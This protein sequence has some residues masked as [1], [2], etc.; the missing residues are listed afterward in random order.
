MARRFTNAEKGK[1]IDTSSVSPPRK[2]IRAPPVDTSDLVKENALT[3]IGRLTNPREQRLWS[4]IPFIS[5]KWELRGRAVGSDLGNSCFQFRFDYEDDL[6]KVLANRPYQ[7]NRWMLILQKWEPIISPDFPSQIPFW[8]NVTGIPLHHWK[9]ELLYSI[10]EE[11]GVLKEYEL[12]K[13][14]A[15]VKVEIDGLQPLVKETIVEFEGGKEALVTLEYT[16]LGK[17]C[18]LCL[19]LS[20][21]V[22]TCPSKPRTRVNHDY[23]GFYAQGKANH[24]KP[25]PAVETRGKSFSHRQDRY[26]NYFGERPSNRRSDY[27]KSPTPKNKKSMLQTLLQHTLMTNLEPLL[28][29]NLTKEKG[30]PLIPATLIVPDVSF[31]NLSPHHTRDVLN[32]ILSSHHFNKSGEERHFNLTK[33]LRKA[34]QLTNLRPTPGR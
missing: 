21:T 1:A 12:T 25:I 14:A 32:K 22:E 7:Y 13:A 23:L 19:R 18:S 34:L 31:M 15:K 26:G 24:L 6:L 17:H 30:L 4:M 20:H 10:G 28:S 2:R 27:T 9:K 5:K 11:I 3:L 8:I 16:R 29:H 33:P